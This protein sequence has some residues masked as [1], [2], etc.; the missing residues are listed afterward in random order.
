MS[1]PN[2]EDLVYDDDTGMYYDSESGNYYT[3]NEDGDV[4]EAGSDSPCN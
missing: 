3:V 1:G 4:Y 2:V